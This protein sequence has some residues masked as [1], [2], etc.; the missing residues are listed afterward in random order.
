VLYILV[1]SDLLTLDGDRFGNT[2]EADYYFVRGRRSYLGSMHEILSDLWGAAFK[3]AA[4]VRAGRAYA[5]HDFTTMTRDELAQFLR[6]A[7]AGAMAAGRSLA[8]RYDFATYRH[9]LD[10]G[11]GSGG[12]SIAMLEANPQ[13]RSTIVDLPNVT[14]LTESFITDAGLVD[15]IQVQS[16]DIVNETPPG[17]YDVAV[18]RNFV[19]VLDPDGARRALQHVGQALRPGGDLYIMGVVMDDTRLSPQSALYMNL[20]FANVYDGGQAYT[21]A[22]HRA[23]L[24]EAGFDTIT[25][26][27]LADGSSIITARKVA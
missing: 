1:D 18:M 26:T 16:A 9:L 6:G 20:V 2:P 3:T 21:E 12:L 27:V 7:N 10:V 13:L 15:H 14:P 22:E 11:G 24:A 8:R 4:S 17:E 5:K 23:W 25:R 19:Q